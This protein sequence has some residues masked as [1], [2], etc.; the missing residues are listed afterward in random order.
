MNQKVSKSLQKLKLQPN[1]KLYCEGELKPFWRGKLHFF[2]FF[3]FLFSLIFLFNISK[4]KSEVV[5]GT[6]LFCL[7]NMF[8]FGVSFLFHC[9]N[10]SPENEVRI[11]FYLFIL[12]F[13][14]F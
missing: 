11:Y 5:I 4:T 9:V 3:F 12:Y 6:I 8:C 14:Y 7:G 2:A 13:S 10:W 1:E